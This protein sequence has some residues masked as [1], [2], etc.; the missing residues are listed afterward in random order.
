MSSIYSTGEDIFVRPLSPRPFGPMGK[1]EYKKHM[2]GHG[3]EIWKCEGCDTEL[4]NISTRCNKKR[5]CSD[6]SQKNRRLV[7]RLRYHKIKIKNEI[8]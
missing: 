6:C 8:H 3:I 1:R 2:N 7:N 5:L 4:N